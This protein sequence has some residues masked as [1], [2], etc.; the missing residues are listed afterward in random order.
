MI[1]RLLFLSIVLSVSLSLNAQNVKFTP[2]KPS[3]GD[4]ITINYELSESP[5]KEEKDI[6]G[7]AYLFKDDEDNIYAKELNLNREGNTIIAEIETD[8]QVKLLSVVFQT[9]DES[10]VDNN[11]KEGY[12]QEM[13]TSN[14][15]EAIEG[16]YIEMAKALYS[17]SWILGLDRDQERALEYTKKAFNRDASLKEDLDNLSM[18]SRLIS[19]DDEAEMEALKSLASDMVKGNATHEELSFAH[20]VLTKAKEEEKAE[21]LKEK[22][23]KKFPYGE[24]A[25]NEIISRFHKTRGQ[26]AEERAVVYH[27]FAAL[28]EEHKDQEFREY[29]YDVLGYYMIIDVTTAYIQ[30]GN[31]EMVDKYFAKIDNK[32]GSYISVL[33]KPLLG[34]SLEAK[35]DQKNLDR[36]AKILTPLVAES[37]AKIA[38]PGASKESYETLFAAKQSLE[39]SYARNLKSYAELHYKMG[40]YEDALKYQSKSIKLMKKD[41]LKSSDYERL[42]IYFE[43]VKGPKETE[44]LLADLI[45]DGNASNKMK[46]RYK[47]LYFENNTLET[48]F[49]KHMNMLEEE[50]N[51][52]FRKEVEKKLI[53]QEAPTF[54]LKNLEG[55]EISLEGLK[56]KIVILDFWA[57]WCGPCKASFPAMKKAQDK[58]TAKYPVEFLFVNAWE[59]VEDKA[60]SAGD[61]IKENNYPFNVPMDLDDKTIAAYKVSGIPTK[62]IIGPDGKIRFKSVGFDGDEDKLIK[63]LEMMIQ[64]AQSKASDPTAS[65]EDE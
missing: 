8:N 35:V 14:K 49:E 29:Y 48:A 61:Y 59:R 3:P 64:I 9:P 12:F 54:A 57:T 55:E 56:G 30:E 44:V 5:L 28:S 42:A 45:K 63:E 16:A 22:I 10:T 27:E 15:E 21:A 24:M 11:N 33:L 43:K 60:K 40:K 37:K 23:L 39:D 36:A 47:E 31:W 20:S 4:K 18:Y 62:F 19:K 34:D 1:R 51:K 50:A 65:L 26:S 25:Q 38:D 17:K 7:I 58:L 52:E 13:Y 32:E 6:K 53:E 46:V 2:E 41:W